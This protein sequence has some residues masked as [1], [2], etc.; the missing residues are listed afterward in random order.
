MKSSQLGG[1][2]EAS[3][4]PV[5]DADLVTTFD[6]KL[7]LDASYSVLIN[8]GNLKLGSELY[9][10][11]DWQNGENSQV[12]FFAKECKIVDGATEVAIIKDSCLAGVVDV[13]M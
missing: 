7:Y 2:K 9:I 6:V 12:S 1:F 8:A 11:I 3:K 4:T 13:Q 5:A 10:V